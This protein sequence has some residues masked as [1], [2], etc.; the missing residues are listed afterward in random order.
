[1][2]LQNVMNTL[3]KN[4]ASYSK[5]LNLSFQNLLTIHRCTTDCFVIVVFYI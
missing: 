2:L 1:M 4:T 5:S 3:L